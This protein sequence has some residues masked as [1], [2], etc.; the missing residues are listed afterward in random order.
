MSMGLACLG[1]TDI[2]DVHD[3]TAPVSHTGE[4]CDVVVTDT[5]GQR[6]RWPQTAKFVSG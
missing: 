6:I 4:F 2:E 5:N 3:G 1:N